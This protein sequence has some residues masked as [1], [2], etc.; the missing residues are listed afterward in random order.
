M[1]NKGVLFVIIA[2]AIVLSVWNV[3]NCHCYKEKLQDYSGYI[4]KFQHCGEDPIQGYKLILKHPK[5]GKLKFIE[6]STDWRGAYNEGDT[7]K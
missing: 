1:K 3:T 6:I 7:I 4:V 5:T 2:F